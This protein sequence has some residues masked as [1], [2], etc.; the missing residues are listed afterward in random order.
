MGTRQGGEMT[1]RVSNP[2]KLKSIRSRTRV[3]RDITRRHTTRERRG[4]DGH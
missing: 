1:N 3:S 2:G 4:A